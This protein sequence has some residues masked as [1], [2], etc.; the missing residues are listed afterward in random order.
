MLRRLSLFLR[1]RSV[2][3][4]SDFIL[5]WSCPA[6]RLHYDELHYRLRCP[7]PFQ[8]YIT[9][10]SPCIPSPPCV[11][12][13]SA[14]TIFE[15]PKPQVPNIKNI[16][17]QAH[18]HMPSSGTS[19]LLV[20]HPRSTRRRLA[21]LGSWSAIRYAHCSQLP[22]VKKNATLRVKVTAVILLAV[23]DH[24]S[25]RRHGIHL[26]NFCKSCFSKASQ[27]LC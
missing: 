1:C 8:F 21:K 24:F 7:A 25:V 12:E 23:H 9:C 22:A 4:A 16:A 15:T 2:A 10:F 13:L 27:H 5:P 18:L 11:G 17:S 3:P 14:V 6:G 26:S 19:Y 20:R